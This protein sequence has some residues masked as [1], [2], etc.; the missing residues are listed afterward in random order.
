MLLKLL[1]MISV[2]PSNI[3]LEMPAVSATVRPFKF[4]VHYFMIISGSH[5][6]FFIALILVCQLYLSE[7]ITDAIYSS[8]SM[9]TTLNMHILN[10]CAH[11]T[12]DTYSHIMRR[13]R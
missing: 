8:L 12:R 7:H 5:R 9:S 6:R 11:I 1:S 4:D 13:A 10:A 3:Q 2:A